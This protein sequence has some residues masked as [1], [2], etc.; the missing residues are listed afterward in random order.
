[1]GAA[2]LLPEKNIL[3]GKAVENI[4]TTW[5]SFYAF[6]LPPALAHYVFHIDFDRFKIMASGLLLVKYY[7]DIIGGL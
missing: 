2:T 5:V 7:N 4:L 3:L 6:Y 1:L